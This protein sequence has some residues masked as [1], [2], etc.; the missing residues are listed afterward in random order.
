MSVKIYDPQSAHS[1][2]N[3][4]E[5]QVISRKRV[6]DHGEVFTAQRE[7]IAMLDLVLD[8]TNRIDSRFL[9]PAC[10]TG[11]FLIEILRRKLAVVES[12]YGKSKY[13]YEKYA[14]LAVSSMYG[15]DILL[16]SLEFCRNRL[17]SYFKLQFEIL[18]GTQAEDD[19][20]K[21]VQYLLQKNIVQ[22]DALTMKLVGSDDGICFVE[23]SLVGEQLKGLVFRYSDI[24]QDIRE[25]DILFTHSVHTSDNGDS[26]YITKPIS[27]YPLT[28]FRRLYE[29]G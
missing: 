16:D 6:V 1:N 7:V 24:Q 17:F 15:I 4:S 28:S 8:E 23:W 22:G 14:I 18:F 2:Y 25:D 9:E 12:R 19:I 26:V 10:G 3:S 27:E 20:L 13:D 29:L 5:K 11:N 21:S